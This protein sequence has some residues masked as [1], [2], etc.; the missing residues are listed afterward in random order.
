MISVFFVLIL[1][2]FCLRVSLRGEREGGREGGGSTKRGGVMPVP[3]LEGEG[4]SEGGLHV[5]ITQTIDFCFFTLFAVLVLIK[6]ALLS[7]R[8]RV[9]LHASIIKGVFSGGGG[10]GREGGGAH[11]HVCT[12]VH[13]VGTLHNDIINILY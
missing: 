13:S 1:K 4:R 9:V 2:G 3:P 5:H 6:R 8:P 10:G 12:T 7:S 11:V